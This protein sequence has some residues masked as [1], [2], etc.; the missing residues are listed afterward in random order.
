MP[1]E[2]PQ[3]DHSMPLDHSMHNGPVSSRCF[4]S[5]SKVYR[6][7]AHSMPSLPTACLQCAHRIP[8]ICLVCPQCTHSMPHVNC[9]YLCNYKWPRDFW[10][11]LSV[12]FQ[13]QV[14]LWLF[15]GRHQRQPQLSL[16]I[17][18][19]IHTVRPSQHHLLMN[20]NKAHP[21]DVI[22]C[23]CTPVCICKSLGWCCLREVQL[24]LRGSFLRKKGQTLEWFN[25]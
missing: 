12:K 1:K 7:C 10:T 14:S 3:C 13:V 20:I 17:R 24:L 4:H 16:L 6:Q 5:L 11:Q 18:Q 9:S 23:M 2:C 25:Q 8:T 15:T 22:Y 19:N 21:L